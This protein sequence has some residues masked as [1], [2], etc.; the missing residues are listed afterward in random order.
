MA[1]YIGCKEC[2][3]RK[4]DGCNILTLEKMLSEGKFNCLLDEHLSINPCADVEVVKYGR[5]IKHEGYDE[6][7]LCHTKTIFGHNYC[8]NC[9]AKMEVEQ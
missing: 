6:C 1:E 8:P 3:S 5:W 4:C 7:N 9:G 2:D